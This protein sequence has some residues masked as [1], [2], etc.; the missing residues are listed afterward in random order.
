MAAWPMLQSDEQARLHWHRLFRIAL[1]QRP[2]VGRYFSW[3]MLAQGAGA[4][5]ES[6][7]AFGGAAAGLEVAFRL[8]WLRRFP[9]A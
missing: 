4:G 5:V 3:S 6:V 8:G 7:L 9:S 1:P 2:R